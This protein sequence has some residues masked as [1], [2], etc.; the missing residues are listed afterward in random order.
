MLPGIT[1][2]IRSRQKISGHSDRVLAQNFDAVLTV[3]VIWAH[4]PYLTFLSGGAETHSK[5]PI[6]KVQ[7]LGQSQ[8][9][10]RREC[11][12]QSRELKDIHSYKRGSWRHTK[13]YPFLSQRILKAYQA[14]YFLRLEDPEGI[15]GNILSQ[16]RGSWNH[17]RQYTFSG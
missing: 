3:I 1:K 14:I 9:Q 17:T 2:E 15:P 16:D 12:R 7:S 4:G 5:T 10:S 8:G 6:R 11:R 13:Q